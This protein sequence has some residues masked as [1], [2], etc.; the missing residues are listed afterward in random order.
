M[1][2]VVM[3]TAKPDGGRTQPPE[4]DI[5]KYARRL[6]TL[7]VERIVADTVFSLLNGAQAKLGRRDARLLIDLAAVCLGHARDYLSAG[8][9][10]QVDGLLGQLRLAQVTAEGHGKQGEAEENDLD[11]VP[12]PPATASATSPAGRTSP[13]S[14]SSKLWVPGR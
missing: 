1:A 3:S 8:L 13:L 2:E 5:R 12:A 10:R 6:R 4:E 9:A 7:P 11:R 14:G